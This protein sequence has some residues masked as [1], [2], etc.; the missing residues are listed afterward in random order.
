MS[1]SA[2]TSPSLIDLADC[3]PAVARR[4]SSGSLKI[5]RYALPDVGS[6]SVGSASV[7]SSSDAQA[8][9]R[10]TASPTISDSHKLPQIHNDSS[11]RSLVPAKR[12]APIDLDQLSV[13]SNAKEPR[14]EH[15]VDPITLSAVLRGDRGA[16]AAY[17]Y[18]K[19]VSDLKDS[20]RCLVVDLLRLR[21]L[22]KQA[23]PSRSTR[24]GS[25]K[26]S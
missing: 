17:R 14:N 6:P 11:N 2:P 21:R 9:S 22:T 23:S 26:A 20:S 10:T 8:S 24:L 3:V 12:L 13:E 4:Y 18:Q 1:G 5:E 25:G 16:L 19:W 15:G 7:A